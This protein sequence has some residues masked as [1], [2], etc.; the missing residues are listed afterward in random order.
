MDREA[1][2]TRFPGKSSMGSGVQGVRSVQPTDPATDGPL[3]QVRRTG[4]PVRMLLGVLLR[5]LAL[6]VFEVDRT[7]AVVV[8]AVAAFGWG[9]GRIEALI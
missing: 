5:A 2:W 3:L 7:I 4:S 6:P 9:R 8:D 1:E